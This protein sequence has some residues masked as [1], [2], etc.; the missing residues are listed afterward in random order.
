MRKM[1]ITLIMLAVVA[2]TASAEAISYKVKY[3][4]KFHNTETAGYTVWTD[5][6]IEDVKWAKLLSSNFDGSEIIDEDSDAKDIAIV[7]KL[8]IQ[9]HTVARGDSYEYGYVK[10]EGKW[11]KVFCWEPKEIDDEALDAYFYM[12]GAFLG[13]M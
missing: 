11:H 13:N 7:K 3:A 12:L 10:V 6:V 8:D 1:M 5:D 4:N 9:K 2:V